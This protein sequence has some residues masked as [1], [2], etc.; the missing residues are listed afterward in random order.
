[1]PGQVYRSLYDMASDQHGYFT[2]EQARAAGIEP[3]TVVMMA[4]R[5]A[6]ERVARGVYRLVHFPL[7]PNA[8]YM[9]ATLWPAGAR[10]VVSHE[11][12]LA[13]HDLSD[14]NPARVHITV[15]R[16]FRVRRGVPGY[17]ALHHADLRPDE[18]EVVD[19]IPVTT[20][21]RAIRDCHAAH[22]GPELVRQAIDDGART[23]R[24]P[25]RTADALRRELLDPP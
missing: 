22:L 1:M 25:A 10:G 16:S 12:A 2:A 5:G 14:V 21:A 6:A 20:P 9:E 17:L 15:P 11:S 8:L 18:V 19:G 7:S 4:R 24:L 23:G 3:M 13:L